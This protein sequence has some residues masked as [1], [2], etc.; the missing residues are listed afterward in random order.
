MS[1]AKAKYDEM[2]AQEIWM[3]QDETEKQL[4]ALTAQLEQ[5]E[6]KNKQLQAKLKKER[7]PHN[8]PGRKNNKSIPLNKWKWKDIPPKSGEK[9]KTFESSEI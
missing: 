7:K 5:I 8:K 2:T 9:T 3:K 6:W 1:V 4:V